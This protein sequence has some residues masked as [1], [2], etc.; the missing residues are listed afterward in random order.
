MIVSVNTVGAAAAGLAAACVYLALVLRRRSA[1]PTLSAFLMVVLGFVGLASGVTLVFLCLTL[2]G[3]RFGSLREY[4]ISIL[5]GGWRSAGCRASRWWTSSAATAGWPRSRA[6][7][8]YR[9]PDFRAGASKMKR[10]TRKTRRRTGSRGGTPG[11]SSAAPAVPLRSPRMLSPAPAHE[12]RTWIIPVAQDG[13]GLNVSH[14]SLCETHG[15]SSRTKLGEAVSAIAEQAKPLP[16][17][18]AGGRGFDLCSGRRKKRYPCAFPRRPNSRVWP[19]VH[20]SWAF[21]S[22]QYW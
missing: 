5:L 3:T 19:E 8:P 14:G 9:V 22:S 12:P 15:S 16:R 18:G 6:L 20:S 4:W 21:P 17:R 13:I 1:A 7:R 10:V 2:P 11:F